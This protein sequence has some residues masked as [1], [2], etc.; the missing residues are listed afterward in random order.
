MVQVQGGANPVE[1]HQVSRFAVTCDAQGFFRMPPLSRV[2]Q[3]NLRAHDGA[4]AEIDLTVCP[5]YSPGGSRADFV[6]Q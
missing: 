6:F 2:A 1:Y 5:N 4:H 3:C